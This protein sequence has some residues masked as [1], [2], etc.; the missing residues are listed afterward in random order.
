MQINTEELSEYVQSV[1]KTLEDGIKNPFMLNGPVKFQIGV[2]N[3]SEKDGSLRL[4]IAGI[5]A[6]RSKEE[7]AKIEF[8][9]IGVFDKAFREKWDEMM[10]QVLDQIKIKT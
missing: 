8:E 5:G 9:V 6:N 10:K 4:S 7:N 2:R 1:L 3:I